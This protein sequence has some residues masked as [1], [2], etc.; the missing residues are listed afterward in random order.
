MA[1]EPAYNRTFACHL[2]TLGKY[3]TSLPW[4]SHLQDGDYN[5]S[6]HPTG[7]YN[8]HE[9]IHVMSLESLIWSKNYFCWYIS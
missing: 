6:V 5:T 4:P 7:H 9:W 8:Y 3:L 1:L 2:L